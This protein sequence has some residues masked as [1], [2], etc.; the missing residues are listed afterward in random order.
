MVCSGERH[1]HAVDH[2]DQLP[3]LEPPD[4]VTWYQP[5]AD[6]EPG[7]MV[8]AVA[9][10]GMSPESWHLVRRAEGGWAYDSVLLVLL[11]VALAHGLIHRVDLPLLWHQVGLCSSQVS[12]PMVAVHRTEAGRWLPGIAP[13]SVGEQVAR[14]AEN[15][16][17]PHTFTP[18]RAADAAGGG[19]GGA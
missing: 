19:G 2:R 17:T 3:E 13:G 4:S 1:A 11:D 9:P 16:R 14:L 5:K 10:Y 18:A 12:H 8:T 15:W 7:P 6:S